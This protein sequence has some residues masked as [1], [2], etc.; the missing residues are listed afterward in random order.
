MIESF[1]HSLSKE[2]MS[3][4]NR[5]GRPTFLRDL[6]VDSLILNLDLENLSDVL[7][8]ACNIVV[9]NFKMNK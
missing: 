7:A 9:D 3:I 2:S 5:E 8:I 4:T 1:V 6:S